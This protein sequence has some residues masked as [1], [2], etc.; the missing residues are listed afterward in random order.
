MSRW[1]VTR[2][3]I[4]DLDEIHDYIARRSPRNAARFIDR[5]EKKFQV[6]SKFPGMGS[7]REAFAPSL[8][9]SPVGDYLIFYRPR[10]DGIEI[11]RVVS[12]YRDLEALFGMRPDQPNQ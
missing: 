1:F 5:I 4:D 8:R 3:A 2:D 6:L 11:I 12:G 9:S 10:E 7:R